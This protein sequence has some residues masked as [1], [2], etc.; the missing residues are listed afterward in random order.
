MTFVQRL[1]RN[2]MSDVLND[3]DFGAALSVW[4]F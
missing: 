4:R 1:V 3:Y 2:L